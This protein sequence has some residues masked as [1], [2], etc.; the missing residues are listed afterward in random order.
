MRAD[1][2]PLWGMEFSKARWERGYVKIDQH[3]FLLVTLEKKGMQQAHQYDDRFLS[4]TE[5]QWVSQNQQSQKR[6]SGQIIKNH[7]QEGMQ[8]HLF[9]RKKGKTPNNKAMAFI[10]CGDVTFIDWEGSEPITIRW[11]L[12]DQVPDHLRQSFGIG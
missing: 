10:Y 12:K 4:P 2:P 8:V 1:I 3:I 11:Q 5:F 6:P 9:V 7:E